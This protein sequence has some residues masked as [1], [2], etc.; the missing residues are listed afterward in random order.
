M[1]ETLKRYGWK[2]VKLL[3]A[4][5]DIHPATAYRVEAMEKMD[6]ASAR[7]SL[8]EICKAIEQ[9]GF[10]EKV[11]A[12]GLSGRLDYSGRA[13]WRATIK[14]WLKQRQSNFFHLVQ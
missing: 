12:S 6:R 5:A 2:R 14:T 4:V 13:K 1:R 8:G 11:E 7:K 3:G 10:I 9:K